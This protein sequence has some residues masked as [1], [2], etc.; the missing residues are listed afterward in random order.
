MYIYIYMSQGPRA[1]PL[2]PGNGHGPPPPPLWVWV[3]W[4]VVGGTISVIQESCIFC[5]TEQSNFK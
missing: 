4:F 2:P 1:P 5:Q 3:G